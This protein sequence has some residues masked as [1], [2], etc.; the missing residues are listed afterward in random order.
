MTPTR[1]AVVAYTFRSGHLH[2]SQW[3]RF[4]VVKTH[5][6]NPCNP[7]KRLAVVKTGPY[8]PLQASYTLFGGKNTLSKG[9]Q[10][11]Y[12]LCVF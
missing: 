12:T 10:A 2:A 11:S 7:P 8:K 6:A 9:L 1:F 5:S 3:S 4:V